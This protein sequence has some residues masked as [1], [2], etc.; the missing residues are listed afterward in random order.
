MSHLLSK[1]FIA[2]Y[3]SL[4]LVYLQAWSIA[5]MDPRAYVAKF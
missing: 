2:I 3:L 1:Y 5:Y 4:D